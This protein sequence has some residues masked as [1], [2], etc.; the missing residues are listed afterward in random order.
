MLDAAP[1][2]GAYLNE[3]NNSPFQ[4]WRLED[5]G[6]GDKKLRQIAT[7]M[8]LDGGANDDVYLHSENGGDFQ[9]WR[10]LTIHGTPLIGSLDSL[11]NADELLVFEQ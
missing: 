1:E 9:L 4:Q 6:D 11:K 7:G 8:L 5:A 3:H 2:R 10:A